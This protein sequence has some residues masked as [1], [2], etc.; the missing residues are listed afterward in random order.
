MVLAMGLLPVGD[1]VAKLLTQVAS[2]AEIAMWRILAQALVLAPLAAIWRGR[3]HGP[4]FSPVVAVSG[5]MVVTVL[6]CL[7]TAFQ[8]MPI[9]TAIAIFFVEPLL[10]TLL[11]GPLL[12]EVAGPRRYVAVGVGLIGAMIVLRPSFAAFGPAAVLPLVAALAYALNMI[13]MRKA[14]RTRAVLTIQLGATLYGAAILVVALV[15]AQAAGIA[16]IR[17]PAAPGIAWAGVAA[18]GLLAAVTFL[19]IAEAFRRG[20]ASVLAPFQ[21]LEI[22]GATIMGYLVFG[23]FPDALTWLGTAIILA[24]GAYVFHREQRAGRRPPRRRRAAR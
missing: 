16:A 2:P 14:T 10:L 7:I 23:D 19:L 13:V 9:A 4:M 18:A 6:T 24:S 11:A 5:L 22:V 17:M 15:V 20:E 3:L 8:V 21:Y 12:G 1:T